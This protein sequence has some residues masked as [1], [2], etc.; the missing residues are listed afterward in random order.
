MCGYATELTVRLLLPTTLSAP[1]AALLQGGACVAASSPPDSTHPD[2]CAPPDN[3]PPD[4]TTQRIYPGGVA[5][6][7]VVLSKGTA[8]SG[9][10]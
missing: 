1:R 8:G 10:L 6:R 2:S 3:S 5:I 9:T 4:S 7:G